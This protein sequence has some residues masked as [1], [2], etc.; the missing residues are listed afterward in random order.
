MSCPFRGLLMFGQSISGGRTGGPPGLEV[1]VPAPI[2]AASRPSG[3]NMNP[4]HMVHDNCYCVRPAAA[5]TLLFAGAESAGRHLFRARAAAIRR[6]I[7][8]AGGKSD[9]GV[10]SRAKDARGNPRR[11]PCEE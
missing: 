8:Q 3:Q 7:V 1:P 5:V 6:A 10:P 2:E 9:T 11:R 4:A